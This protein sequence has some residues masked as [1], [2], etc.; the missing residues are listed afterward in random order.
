MSVRHSVRGRGSLYRASAAPNASLWPQSVQTWGP[1]LSVQS[2]ST[3]LHPLD[4]FKLVQLGP[5][6]TGPQSRPPNTLHLDTFKLVNYEAR[7]VGKCAVGIRLKY[8]LVILFGQQPS[9]SLVWDQCGTN[10]WPLICLFRTL[11]DVE[12]EFKSQG[13][14]G[15]ISGATPPPPKMY[16]WLL[17]TT[18]SPTQTTY[19]SLSFHPLCPQTYSHINLIILTSADIL[20]NDMQP[21]RKHS[22]RMNTAHLPTVCVSVVKPPDVS[23][24]W[25][26]VLK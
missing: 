21:I 24:D 2:P 18:L 4:M 9:Q 12:L 14:F 15:V 16:F 11:V 13:I 19:I 22:S 8:L 10:L 3:A 17:A 5:H 1:T 6:C 26:G 23:I 25:R 20:S 7:I